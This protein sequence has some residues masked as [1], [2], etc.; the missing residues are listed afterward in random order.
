MCVMETEQQG[1]GIH[2]AEGRVLTG[3][4][5]KEAD[6]QIPGEKI[7][8]DREAARQRGLVCLKVRKEVPVVE[9]D[10]EERR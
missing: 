9:R 5:V 8:P 10:G 1:N 6:I 7:I 4:R 3:K 2:S